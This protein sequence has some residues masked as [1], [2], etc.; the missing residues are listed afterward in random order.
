MLLNEKG[1]FTLHLVL[2]ALS[3][4]LLDHD[5]VLLGKV[6]VRLNHVVQVWVLVLKQIS[7]TLVGAVPAQI[8]PAV[9][10]KQSLVIELLLGQHRLHA[11]GVA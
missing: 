11:L 2:N 5:L 4:Q 10:E 3:K 7:R 6:I 8:A 9:S 1:Q